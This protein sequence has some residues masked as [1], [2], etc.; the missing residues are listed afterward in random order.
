[1]FSIDQL[2]GFQS[3][4]KVFTQI[5]PFSEIFGWKIFVKNMPINY[6]TLYH[7]KNLKKVTI[8]VFLKWNINEIKNKYFYKPFGGSFGNSPKIINLHRKTP[9]KYGVPTFKILS[10]LKKNLLNY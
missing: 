10:K 4:F 8:I 6:N 7:N 5:S 1:M 3:F 2:F 9:P